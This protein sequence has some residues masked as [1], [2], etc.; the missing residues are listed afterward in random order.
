MYGISI[1]K[2]SKNAKRIHILGVRQPAIEHLLEQRR[3]AGKRGL[4]T[5]LTRAAQ[6]STT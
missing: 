6:M 3:I 5:L 4:I 1:A 2:G